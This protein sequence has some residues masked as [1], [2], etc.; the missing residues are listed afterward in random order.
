[1][2][3]GLITLEVI[4]MINLQKLVEQVVVEVV[5]DE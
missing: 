3:F 1:M 2:D 4:F 5:P